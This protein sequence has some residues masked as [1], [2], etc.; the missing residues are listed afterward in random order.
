[1]IRL[2]VLCLAQRMVR[3][4][5]PPQPRQRTDGAS[6][7]K[8]INATTKTPPAIPV[9]MNHPGSLFTK[10][11]IKKAIMVPSESQRMMLSHA[12]HM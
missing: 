12:V 2:A 5:V 10:A 4:S 3:S 1:M 6:S 7:R 11:M 8:N 9:W